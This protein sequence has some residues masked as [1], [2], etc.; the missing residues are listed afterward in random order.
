MPCE[1]RNPSELKRCHGPPHSSGGSA[2]D[3]LRRFKCWQHPYTSSP[4]LPVTSNRQVPSMDSD[5]NIFRF[6]RLDITNAAIRRLRNTGSINER[7]SQL[8]AEN[9]A[10]LE[11][12]RLDHG[13]RNPMISTGVAGEIGVAAA[14][15]KYTTVEMTPWGSA[16]DVSYWQLRFG[17]VRVEVR[18]A[19]QSV[20]GRFTANGP[21]AS[22]CDIAV[23]LSSP[24]SAYESG[25]GTIHASP[26]SKRDMNEVAVR[27]GVPVNGKLSTLGWALSSNKK[28]AGLIAG[29]AVTFAELP[30]TLG[31]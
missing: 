3:G 26:L 27:Q 2:S 17:G 28:I 23:L 16:Y 12:Y 24:L 15:G 8:F 14:L 20:N 7:L 30:K 4:M 25:K 5:F 18:T 1:E 22:K 13:L 11:G 9:V 19:V 21:D 10:A 6:E 31:L 29:N